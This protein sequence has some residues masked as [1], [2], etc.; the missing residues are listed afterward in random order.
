MAKYFLP[1]RNIINGLLS[2]DVDEIAFQISQTNE[3]KRLVIEL[4]T[5]GEATS[6]LYELGE[7]SL[8][9]ELEGETIVVDGGGAFYSSF[10]VKPYKGGFEITANPI[11]DETN[12][13]REFGEDIVGLN[14]E[15]L[16]IV[17]N[18]YLDA[19]RFEIQ[20]KIAA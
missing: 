16:Q 7:D 14:A 10:D 18:F 2:L 12:L 11:K 6:Q 19:F 3:F 4:N 20:E 13:F 17:I 8:G 5:E 15:N 9:N 1:L